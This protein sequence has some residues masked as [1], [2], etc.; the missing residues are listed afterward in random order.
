MIKFV[1]CEL[2][3][4]IKTTEFYCR[5]SRRTSVKGVEWRGESKSTFI[6]RE[7]VRELDWP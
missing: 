6:E 3:E 1:K 2:G 4:T 7:R 5:K